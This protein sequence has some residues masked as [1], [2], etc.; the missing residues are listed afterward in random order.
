MTAR[1]E[2][3]TDLALPL[4]SL[5]DRR[6]LADAC[7]AVARREGVQPWAVEKDFYLTRLLWA[8]AEA[9]GDQLLLKGGT[10]LS[11]CDLGYRRL[12]EDV[13]VVVPLGADERPSRHRGMNSKVL[14][15]VRDALRRWH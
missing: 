12:S 5:P 4:P 13:D 1:G 3:V 7:R 10:C 8:M 14:N 6:D 2:K 9:L 15:R 11:K